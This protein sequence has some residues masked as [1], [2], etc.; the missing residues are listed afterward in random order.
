MWNY[1]EN[2]QTLGAAIIGILGAFTAVLAVIVNYWLSK[3][4]SETKSLS[5][6]IN[7]AHH[8]LALLA[9]EKSFANEV[10]ISFR[11][12]LL[13]W[14]FRETV[15]VPEFS[16]DE[17]K[18]WLQSER[19]S[20]EFN[21]SE[22]TSFWKDIYSALNDF[23][24]PIPD[25]VSHV[26]W[27]LGRTVLMINAFRVMTEEDK[28]REL[29][30]TA[31]RI[32]LLLYTSAVAGG[33]LAKQLTYFVQYPKHYPKKEIGIFQGK[34]LIYKDQISN[35]IKKD[36]LEC[37]FDFLMQAEALMKKLPSSASS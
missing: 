11:I 27:S 8:V 33:E 28:A 19:L 22:Y 10:S 2:H 36:T 1:F 25:I 9:A 3:R 34:E 16:P 13:F 20:N 29:D 23:P 35:S 6:K 5:G 21:V 12:N 14:S 7:T 37:K 4:Q 32:R 31:D 24:H 30:K 15:K 26:M 17:V 18:A